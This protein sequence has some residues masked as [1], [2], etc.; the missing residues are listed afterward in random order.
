[1]ICVI[2]G[3]NRPNSKTKS[4]ARYIHSYLTENQEEE[5]I[6]LDLSTLTSDTISDVMY[7][8]D[9]Q[10]PTIS[11]IQDDVIIPCDRWVIVSPEYN[12]SFAGILKLFIDALSVRRYAETFAGKHVA[13]VGTSSGRA[14]NLRGLEHLTGLLNY[15]KIHV[16]P[17]KLPI[18]NIESVLSDGIIKDE[19]TKK[20]IRDLMDGFLPSTSSTL[21]YETRDSI[22]AN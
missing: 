19:E 18:S 6:F 5:V 8:E 1:M 7:R 14:G 9:G 10:S 20:S 21:S 11:K 4:I 15:L 12:G 3:T 2:S 17:D 13:L 16:Y 22:E